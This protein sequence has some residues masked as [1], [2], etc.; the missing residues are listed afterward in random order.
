MKISQ[1]NATLWVVL[2]ILIARFVILH[3]SKTEDHSVQPENNPQQQ[4]SG[5]TINPHAGQPGNQSVQTAIERQLQT[6]QVDGTGTIVKV[7][8][9]DTQGDRHQRL[10]VTVGHGHTVLIAHNI[11]IASRIPDVREGEEI[12]FSGE[13]KW[14][15]KGG[16]VHWTHH[17]PRNRHPDGWL[18]YHGKIYQ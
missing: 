7:L 2:V 3:Y 13:F 18:R 4:S 17:D 6:V 9:E 10:L 14:N 1:R 16:V 15:E 12:A 8:P 11:D 5:Q